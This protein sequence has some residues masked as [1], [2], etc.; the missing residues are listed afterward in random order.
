MD[1]YGNA[2]KQPDSDEA[3]LLLGQTEG[4]VEYNAAGRVIKGEE[5]KVRPTKIPAIFRNEYF[6][7][8]IL[9]EISIASLEN[10]SFMLHKSSSDWT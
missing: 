4:Y 1:T 6:P 7:Q 10:S 8:L 3:R 5:V 2:A 9:N